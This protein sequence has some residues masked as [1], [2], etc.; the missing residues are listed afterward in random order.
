[1]ETPIREWSHHHPWG[2]GAVCMPWWALPPPFPETPAL[3]ARRGKTR[4]L[5]ATHF[6]EPGKE[7]EKEGRKKK[8]R[9]VEILFS[10]ERQFLWVTWKMLPI[11]VQNSTRC[12]AYLVIISQLHLQ[13]TKLPEAEQSPNHLLHKSLFLLHSSSPQHL[14]NPSPPW[15]SEAP[16]KVPKGSN[17]SSPMADA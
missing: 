8:K 15:G 17:C 11:S 6:T 1:M 5:Q 14:P 4:N 13:S 2:T 3:E 12:I 7:W 9:N 10:S 16:G